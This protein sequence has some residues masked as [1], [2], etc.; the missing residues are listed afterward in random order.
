M[1]RLIH[2]GNKGIFQGESPESSHSL[3]SSYFSMESNKGEHPN[4]PSHSAGCQKLHLHSIPVLCQCLHCRLCT[5]ELAEPTAMKHGSGQ[6]WGSQG[7]RIFSRTAAWINPCSTEAGS[8][9]SKACAEWSSA[10]RP[11]QH[12]T[13]GEVKFSHQNFL[14]P[15]VFTDSRH[16]VELRTPNLFWEFIFP[17]FSLILMRTTKSNRQLSIDCNPLYALDPF[18]ANLFVLRLFKKPKFKKPNS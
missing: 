18:S 2:S 11:G 3:Q 12:F 13:L 10:E 9:T 15:H 7:E 17:Q 14:S 8:V 16:R 6:A 5:C 4:C 1:P